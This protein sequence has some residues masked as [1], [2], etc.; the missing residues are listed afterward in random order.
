MAG[1]HFGPPDHER[2]TE[3]GVV[4]RALRTRHAIAVIA[5]VE[6]DGVVGE[7]IGFE[8]PEDLADLAVHV[9]DVVVH[10]RE[11]FADERRV[12]VVRRDHDARGICD[13]RLPFTCG[14]RRKYL[15]LVRHFEVEDRK[16][17]L[18]LVGPIAPVRA[19]AEIVPD[20]K[21]HAELVVGLRAVARVI[22]R[23][24]QIFGKR[25]HIERRHREVR[26]GQLGH[27]I[28]RRAHV[29][30][31]DRRL[32]HARDDRRAAGRA[33]GRRRKCARVADRFARQPI[34]HRAFALPHRRRRRGAGS[35][36]RSRSRR[37]SAS[38]RAAKP[39]AAPRPCSRHTTARTRAIFVTGAFPI[40]NP[41]SLVST[42]TAKQL[43]H[44][45]DRGAVFRI[46]SEIA[47]L[48]RIVDFVV[49]LDAPF[50]VVPLGVPPL[51]RADAVAQ[52]RRIGGAPRR[53]C[54]SAG[55][56]HS[57]PGFSAAGPASARGVPAARTAAPGLQAWDRCRGTPRP[58]K[59]DGLSLSTPGPAMMKGARAD[60]SNNVCFIHWP[61]SPR[62]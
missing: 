7:P 30:R 37:C 27:A 38:T 58:A 4:Q 52:E 57:A 59:R 12:G 56:G 16:E 36:P 6:D 28:F 45:R 40:P 60:R 22:T 32:I 62:W 44:L 19:R 8:L 13:E 9:G 25:L 48:V 61:R 20:R 21:R 14:A 33:H 29:L 41:Y 18:A 47:Q 5:P 1:A 49:Q 54:V 26:P 3:T 51:L 43:L 34:Q 55:C 39:A 15:A 2:H 17:R 31:A 53:T 24:A 10:A 42:D 50:A 11:L 23:R 46:G 35:C